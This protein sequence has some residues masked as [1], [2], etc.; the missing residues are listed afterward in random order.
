MAT[1]CSSADAL[2]KLLVWV[3]LYGVLRLVLSPLAPLPGILFLDPLPVLAPLALQRCGPGT[4]LRLFPPL[5]LTELLLG[6]TFLLAGTR[7]LVTCL[8]LAANQRAEQPPLRAA[9]LLI[10]LLPLLQ[11]N[12]HSWSLV[13]PF[14]YLAFVGLC[15]ATLWLM[16][17]RPAFEAP[18]AC[19]PLILTTFLSLLGLSVI[20]GE[21]CWPPP[22]QGIASPLSVRLLTLLLTLGALA[23]FLRNLD[24]RSKKLAPATDSKQPWTALSKP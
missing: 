23:F 19:T 15:Q 9:A 7:T 12:L 17:L 3:I 6:S 22:L 24:P 11:A 18:Y 2:G 5:L 13:W 14:V 4:P 16:L 8:L 1:V 21:A 10:I 20:P